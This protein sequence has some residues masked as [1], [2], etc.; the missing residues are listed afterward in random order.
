MIP[1]E[2]ALSE[3][4]GTMRRADEEYARGERVSLED[5][6]HELGVKSR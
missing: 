6:R 5:L 3:E 1:L 4:I 2:D